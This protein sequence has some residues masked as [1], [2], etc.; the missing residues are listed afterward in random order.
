MATAQ[1]LAMLE[2]RC[3]WLRGRAYLVTEFLGGENI[4]TRFAPYVQGSLPPDELAAVADMFASLNRASISHGDMKGDNLFW[5][6]GRWALVD[7]DATR[8]HR[9]RRSFLRA[10]ARDRERFLRNWS[11]SSELFRQLEER[12]PAV[13]DTFHTLQ[14]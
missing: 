13:P 3:C 2:H 11:A 14:G 8:Q 5:H 7:L 6:G 10:L 9:R 12:I 1:P 4:L